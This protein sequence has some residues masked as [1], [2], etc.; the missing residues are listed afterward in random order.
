MRSKLQNSRLEIQ[1]F[2]RDIEGADQRHLQS[3]KDS[4][5]NHNTQKIER[6]YLMLRT[7]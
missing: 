2:Y 6:K 7:I 5:G 3:Q 4:V 1:H